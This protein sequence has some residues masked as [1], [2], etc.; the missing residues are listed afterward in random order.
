MKNTLR[1]IG[2][3]IV[4][5]ATGIGAGDMIAATAGG[6]SLGYT[7]LWAVIIGAVLKYVLN[8]GIARYQLVSGQAIPSAWLTRLPR[9]FA[10]YFIIYL[11]FW[12]FIVA[13]ALIAAT[14]LAAHSLWPILGVNEWGIIHSIIAMV[15][16]LWGT[17]RYFEGLMKVMIATLFLLVITAVFL[18]EPDING[19]LEGIFIPRLGDGSVRYALAVI[20]GVGGSVTLLSYGYWI[21]EKSW[22]GP[23]QIPKIRTDLLVAYAL[24]GLF[25]LAVVIIAANLKPE[26]VSG[27]Q[28][29]LALADELHNAT[30]PIGRWIFLIGFYGAVFSSMLGVWQGVPY[31]FAD[32]LKS[33]KKEEYDL[34]KL[35]KTRSYRFYLVFLAIPP[36][37]LL[38]FQ[39]PVWLIVTYSVIGALFMPFLT[40][41]L[42]WLNNK[43][44][45]ISN[46]RN[47]WFVNLLLILSL[48]LFLYLGVAEL[49][50][51]FGK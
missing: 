30:G 9:F 4:V 33:W 24:T 49:I 20:G 22:K 7:I 46:N 13:A 10:W 18:V 42:L 31:L 29:I 27:S 19:I 32:F 51:Q 37:I 3:G 14:G 6:A 15:F 50:H 21:A 25:G 45:W 43:K 35:H 28:I 34:Q 36:A 1:N 23:A 8:E 39:K 5:A 11:L 12:S 40:V 47:S 17:Y 41:T 16:V 44:E 26:V 2:P 38:Y 48:L